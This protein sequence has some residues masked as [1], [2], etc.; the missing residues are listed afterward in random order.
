VTTNDL[1]GDGT[2]DDTPLY[3][4]DPA[5]Q[6][7]LTLC[8]ADVVSV[9]GGHAAYLRPESVGGTGNCAGGSLDGDTD[10]NDRVVQLWRSGTT[11]ENLSCPATA[12][13]LSDTWLAALVDERA[14]NG[15]TSV[16]PGGCGGACA[17]WTGGTDLN[18]DC[19]S[20]DTVVMLHDVTAGAGTCALP[21]SN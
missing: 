13:S 17:T 8:P 12:I 18:G 16:C 14:E 10:T 5:T 19:D 20:N 9:A 15:P 2:L 3:V 7:G 1:D 6:S 4:F 11:A 21:T